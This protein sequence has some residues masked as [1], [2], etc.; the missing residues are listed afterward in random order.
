M[1]RSCKGQLDSRSLPIL[2]LIEEG[3]ILLE[4]Q[5]QSALRK[6]WMSGN[7][8]CQRFANAELQCYEWNNRSIAQ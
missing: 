4:Y 6:V 3:K 5:G 7:N 1:V 2:Q 8:I